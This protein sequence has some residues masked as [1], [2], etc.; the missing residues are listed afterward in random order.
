MYPVTRRFLDTVTGPHKA[1]VRVQVLPPVG[2]PGG[3][4]Q[5]GPTPTGGTDLPLLRGDVRMSSTA[6]VKATLDVTVS[7]DYWDLVTPYGVELF[8]ER[9]IDFGDGTVEYAPLGYFGIEEIDQHR[10]P[11]GPIKIS[12]SDRTAR[13]QRARILYPYQVPPGTTHTQL[14]EKL[15]NGNPVVAGEDSRAYGMFFNADVPITWAAYDPDQVRVPDGA[16]VED[17]VYEYLAKLVGS[18]GCALRFA[19]TGELVVGAADMPPGAAPVYAVRNG[20]GGTLISTS[21]KVSRRGVYNIVVARGS[22][23]AVPTGYRLAYNDDR[24]SPL[25]WQGPFGAVPRYYASPLLRTSEQAD[26]AAETTLARYKGL[27]TSTSVT[28][29]PNPALDALDVITNSLGAGTE[30]H[31]IDD[32]TIP[33]VGSAPVEIVTRT[34]NEIPDGDE[35]GGGQF[36]N[37]G[38]P[39]GPSTATTA[40]ERFNWGAPLPASEEFAAA[41]LDPAKW[42]VYADAANNRAPAQVQ[43]VNGVLTITGLADGTTGG[44][45]HRFA[46]QYGRWEIR[47]R[48]TRSDAGV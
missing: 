21:R 1:V 44:V 19:R 37:P 29:V 40:A 45:E 41:T 47:A 3:A 11:Y 16:L 20:E 9:G 12:A 42:T 5:F 17:D 39:G 6:D 28:M 33:L 30:T 8:A 14:F 46:Q 2:G 32:I 26:L 43:V 7:G 24:D 27:P 15:V 36:P 35:G 22:D 31:L 34:L 4:P 18:R 38:E 48:S 13:L 23:P 25:W 10:A